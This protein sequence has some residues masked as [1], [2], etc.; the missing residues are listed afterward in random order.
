MKPL[1]V[2]LTCLLLVSCANTNE[3]AANRF[4]IGGRPIE[5]TDALLAQYRQSWAPG[6][7]VTTVLSRADAQWAMDFIAI[8]EGAQRKPG[9]KSLG[10]SGKDTWTDRTHVLEGRSIR[11]GI[12]D[13]IWR[14]TACGQPR[15]YRVVNPSGSSELVVYELTDLAR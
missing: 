6:T 2:L 3:R 5:L 11:S 8:I 12:F 4:V 13:E 1:S 10:F 7:T 9:C 15:Q 14:V